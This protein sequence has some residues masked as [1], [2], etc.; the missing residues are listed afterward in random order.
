MLSILRQ[1]LKNLQ[2]SGKEILLVDVTIQLP[3]CVLYIRAN[4]P[5]RHFVYWQ[6]FQLWCDLLHYVWT[7]CK[8]AC[9]L[10]S[11]F[12]KMQDCV[13]YL[14]A[15]NFCILIF[16]RYHQQPQKREYISLVCKFIYG[17]KKLQNQKQLKGKNWKTENF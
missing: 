16:W 1:L 4:R 2:K 13:L 17:C 12:Y 3:E 6:G 15:C 8:L 9:S 7:L 10:F 14:W 11:Q 5:K